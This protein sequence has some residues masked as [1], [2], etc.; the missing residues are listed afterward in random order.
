MFRNNERTLSVENETPVGRPDESLAFS[1]IKDEIEKLAAKKAKDIISQAKLEAKEI[2]EASKKQADDIK[3]SI[4]DKAKNEAQHIK[5]K[6][7]SKRKLALR[8]DYLEV[9][10]QVINDFF[11][12]AR[13]KLQLYTQ[14]P[15]YSEFLKKL[16]LESG[17]TLNGGE[18]ILHLRKE[19]K[20]LLTQDEL[21]SIAK[22]ITE[23]TGTDTKIAVSDRDLKSLGGIILDRIDGKMYVENTL[24][25]RLE[26]ADDD[27]RVKLID[28]LN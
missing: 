6:E 23:A 7:I 4:I 8:M 11:L 20:N 13:S 28:L 16:I 3:K 10:E 21:D 17:I 2:I 25:A 22:E 27:I 19:D 24:E 15:E 1:R 9:R 18:F 12:E 26:R 14:T 5:V